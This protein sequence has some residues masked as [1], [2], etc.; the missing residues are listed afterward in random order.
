MTDFDSARRFVQL[1]A[2]L[3]DRRRFEHLFDGA[4]AEGVTAAVAAYAN[5]DGGYA[6]LIEP[7]VRTTT[8]QPIA[9]LTAFDVLD[10]IGGAAHDAT[11]AWL[12][13]VADVDGGIPFSLPTVDDAPHAPWMASTEGASLHM[14][15]AVVAGAIRL[16]AQHPWVDAATAFCLERI[17]AT[18]SLS[19]YETKYAIELL[20][21]LGD[22]D[23]LERVCARIP[24]GGRLPVSGG[25]EG[26]ALSLLTLSPR[27][28]THVRGLLPPDRVEAELDALE[29][30]QGDDGAWT[31]GWLAWSPA[32][33][34]EWRG[35]LTVDALTT[36]RVNGRWPARTGTP[37]RAFPSR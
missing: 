35:R 37:A 5:P 4:P 8:S 28:G 2:R 15:S 20:E 11:F 23:R 22:T 21:A 1:H 24:P 32:V 33:T 29:R 25:V 27:P 19:A 16:G 14:T 12:Q 34:H 26:E 3:I 7:D 6:A 17:D 36:L 13:S 9:A 10:E 30:A 18:A 31:P